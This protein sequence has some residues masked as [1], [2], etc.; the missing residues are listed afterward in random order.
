[1]TAK[2][3]LANNDAYDFCHYCKQLKN[4]FLLI[5]CKYSSK[6]APPM[7]NKNHPSSS[8]S[9]NYVPYPYEPQCYQVKDIK[10]HNADFQNK[11]QI[12]GLMESTKK[13][14]KIRNL[15]V[16]TAQQAMKQQ[17]EMEGGESVFAKMQNGI[18]L[19]TLQTNKSMVPRV[20]G[21]GTKLKSDMMPL[22]SHQLM[23]WLQDLDINPYT[24]DPFD[25]TQLSTELRT[26]YPNF[27]KQ[28][29][30]GFPQH[31]GANQQCKPTQKKCVEYECKRK[32]CTFCLQT[33][34][35][36]SLNDIIRNKN[37][38]CHHCTGYCFCTR[39][40]RQEI[41]T[42]L[43]GYLISLG[44]NL[45]V[46]KNSNVDP[47]EEQPEECLSLFDQII[48]KQFNEHLEVTLAYN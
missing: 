29:Y 10:I 48:L 3:Q 21:N 17:I 31:S 47:A 15:A 24:L 13:N 1:M 19:A 32:F 16:L 27:Y 6:N 33:N 44:G 11:A 34:F 8:Q 45:N 25:C 35:D 23:T 7:Y 37:W 42:Q 9:V 22:P 41:T 40:Q 2:S 26:I 20:N 5:S 46:L 43:K 30:Q 14:L 38:H 12:R 4:K 18:D 28:L 39:C 36:E